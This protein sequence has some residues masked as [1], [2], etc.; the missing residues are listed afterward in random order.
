MLPG[1]PLQ[2]FLEDL[3]SALRLVLMTNHHFL[4]DYRFTERETGGEA[5]DLVLKC[6]LNRAA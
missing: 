6:A 2:C 4:N 3:V 1:S 5:I